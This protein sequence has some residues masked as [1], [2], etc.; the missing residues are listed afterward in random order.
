MRAGFFI[1]I[2]GLDGAGKTT[3]AQ[4][5]KNLF[6]AQDRPAVVF[7]EPTLGPLGQKIRSI[8]K[9][10]RPT[11]LTPWAELELFVQDRAED[12][13][14][15]IRPALSLGQVVILDRYIISNLI[16]QGALGLD[17][18][19][20]LKANQDFPWPDATI[21]LDV[22]PAVGLKRVE[23]RGEPLQKAFE[24]WPYL[25]KVKAILDDIEIN[26]GPHRLSG[27]FRLNAQLLDPETLAQ[28]AFKLIWPLL[29]PA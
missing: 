27:L 1:A 6:L 4:A 24:N 3:L 21:I 28:D 17:L 11:W 8:S 12:V 2:E 29:P 16:Y 18:A 23:F 19:E 26:L 14:Q 15:N 7:R 22:D 13:A 5:L 20:I 9:G 25:S 10:E